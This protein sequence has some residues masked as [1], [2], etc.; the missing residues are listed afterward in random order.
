M[1]GPLSSLVSELHALREPTGQGT[2]ARVSDRTTE[3]PIEFR[4]LF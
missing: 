3:R 1:G 2:T 4:R